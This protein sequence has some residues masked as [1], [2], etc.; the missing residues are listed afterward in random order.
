MNTVKGIGGG[1]PVSANISCTAGITLAVQTNTHYQDDLNH[2]Y[3][4][5][6][7]WGGSRARVAGCNQTTPTQHT[8][9]TV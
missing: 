9:L 1:L 5:N 6:R 2:S 8:G 4:L 3:H 7:E